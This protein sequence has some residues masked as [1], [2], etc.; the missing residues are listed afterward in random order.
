MKNVARARV[1][2]S[3]LDI[4]GCFSDRSEPAL[5]SRARGASRPW[6]SLSG[7]RAARQTRWYLGRGPHLPSPDDGA[8]IYQRIGHVGSQR[9]ND[10]GARLRAQLRAVAQHWWIVVL[11]AA[12]TGACAYLYADTRPEEYRSTTRLL[13]KGGDLGSSLLGVGFQQS[14]AES[15]A[16]T[17]L[18]LAEQPVVASRVIRE[19]DLRLT[20]D[21]LLAKVSSGIEGNSRL[22]A[23]S[24]TDRDGSQATGLAN[25]YA[26]QYIAFR[27]DAARAEITAALRSVDEQLEGTIATDTSPRVQELRDRRAQLETLE[28]LQTGGAQVIQPAIGSGDLVSA[29]PLKYAI[30]GV[31]LGLLLGV[32]LAFLRNRLDPRLKREEDVMSMLPGVPIL[33]S[34]PSWRRN[35]DQTI[36]SEGFRALHTMLTFLDPGRTVHSILITSSTIGE[37][38]TTTSLNLALA[39]AER[40]ESVIVLEGD[41]RRRGLSTRLDIF[42]MPGVSEILAG[43]GTVEEFAVNVSSRPESTPDGRRGQVGSSALTKTLSGNLQ[44]VPGGHPSENPH[45]LLT[46]DRVRRLLGEATA[47]ADTVI[48]DGTPLGLVNDML[49]VAGRVDAVIVIVHLNQTRR[50]ELEHL[51]ALL[52]HARIEPFGIVLFG[53][54]HGPA[55]GAYVT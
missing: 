25:G 32:A 26:E 9:E 24:A 35:P 51:A 50:N 15:E 23:I 31:F 55:S 38:K 5:Y 3:L 48:V 42:D 12:L 30:I 47:V 52:S 29:E 27:R 8:N 2:C 39:I 53:T 21:E 4:R 6:L 36:Q 28:S 17:A 10:P 44:V 11:C 7:C 45:S 46:S 37:G 34:I 16:A 41:V 43:E 19:L 54:D 1:I 18:A 40:D 20:T 22:M 14:D 13:L 33:A 49:P